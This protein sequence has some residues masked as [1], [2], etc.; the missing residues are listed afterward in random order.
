[1]LGLQ[2]S[3]GIILSRICFI[4][5]NHQSCTVRGIIALDPLDVHM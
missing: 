4:W 5:A 2:Q 1:M 3:K